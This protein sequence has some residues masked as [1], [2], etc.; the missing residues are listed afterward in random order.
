MEI[1]GTYKELRGWNFH[2]KNREPQNQSKIK[3]SYEKPVVPLWKT[4]KYSETPQ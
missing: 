4:A 3:V 2:E 1:Y